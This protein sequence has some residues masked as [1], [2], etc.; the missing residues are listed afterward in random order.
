VLLASTGI[1]DFDGLHSRKYDDEVQLYAFDV[2]AMDGD[3]LRRLPLSMRNKS[4]GVC[5]SARPMAAASSRR[6]S[7]RAGARLHSRALE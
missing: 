5:C 7:S 6:T 3:D 2:L 1:S 4:S